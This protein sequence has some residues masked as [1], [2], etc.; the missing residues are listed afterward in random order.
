LIRDS[1]TFS[2]VL[3]PNGQGGKIFQGYLRVP[4]S[5]GV[6]AWQRIDMPSSRRILRGYTAEEVVSARVNLV[7]HFASGG[8]SLYESVLNIV[9]PTGTSVTLEL[10]ARDDLGRV[11]GE[12]LRQTLGPGQVLRGNILSLFRV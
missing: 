6:V 12:S 9:N 10:K 5:V 11:I 2:A 4:S 7:P 3:P 1:E 8:S